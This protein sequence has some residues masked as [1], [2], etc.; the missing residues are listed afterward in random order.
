MTS[1][2]RLRPEIAALPPYRQGKQAA[3]DAFKLSSNENP[4]E[5]LPGVVEALRGAV[6]VNRY[7]DA[8]ASALRA[9]LADKWGVT[10]DEVH[11]GAGS[12]SLLNQ[13]VL[14]AAAPG[15]EVVYAW[16]SFEAY[17]GIVT[18]SSATSVPVPL[19]A[20]GSHDLDAMAAAVTDRTRLVI[21]CSPN[22]PTGTTVSTHDFETFMAAVPG[23]LLVVLDEAYAEF[24]TADDAVRGGSLTERHPN[25]VV[26]RTFSKAYGLAALRVGY[27][28]G[29]SSV[30]DAARATAIPLSVTEQGQAAALASLELE[31][32]LLGRVARLATLRDQVRQAL[33]DQGWS[34]PDAQGNFVWL[35][36]GDD[37]ARAA[38]VFERHG[39]VVRAFAPEGVRITIGEPA[40]V[41][42]L[43]RAAREL[44]GDTSS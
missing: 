9:A 25:L 4:F 19:R 27:A 36:T 40:S 38:E 5:P 33:L 29:A 44:R 26:L 3:A 2:V 10:T 43:L 28:I 30:L 22:N 17:P 6:A 7:P 31:G 13:F 20:D 14:A 41:D 21:V 37:T 12:V 23:D 35:A 32:E 34:V 24:V 8:S 39:I 16:R 15:D 11:V 18:V 42:G 1:P